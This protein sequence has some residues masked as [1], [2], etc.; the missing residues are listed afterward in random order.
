[1]GQKVRPTGFRTGIMI[2]WQS[3]WYAG[4]KEFSELLVED[5]K[6]RR[7]IK[8]KHPGSGIAR[9]RIERTREKVVV[10]IHSGRVGSIIGKKGEKIDRLTKQLEALIHRHI[11]IKTIEVPR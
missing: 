4:K 6:V 9:I 7:F 1:M 2:V 10:F 11:E 3:Q 8:K 5:V